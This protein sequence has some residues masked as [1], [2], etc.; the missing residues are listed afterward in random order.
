MEWGSGEKKF[1]TNC[2]Y[3]KRHNLQEDYKTMLNNLA[4]SYTIQATYH[5]ASEIKRYN[6]MIDRLTLKTRQ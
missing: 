1:I 5:K 4:W 3:C 2:I 6:F